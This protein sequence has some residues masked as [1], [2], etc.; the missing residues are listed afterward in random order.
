MDSTFK[1]HGALAF[2]R[3]PNHL[4]NHLCIQPAILIQFILCLRALNQ[5]HF[6]K[7]VAMYIKIF[8]PVILCIAF[9]S[10]SA[11]GQDAKKKNKSPV[12]RIDISKI[13]GNTINGKVASEPTEKSIII[14]IH[15]PKANVN[16]PGNK[17]K[18][19]PPTPDWKE[20]EVPIR[21]NTKFR[22]KEPVE[23][24]DEKGNIKVYTSQDL[25][26]LKGSNPNLPGY[27]AK[28]ENIVP[29]H[30]VTITLAKQDNKP[31]ASMIM[32]NGKDSSD[33]PNN[34]P[35]NPKGKK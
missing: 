14:Q 20:L 25:K 32:V 17:G 1:L 16:P 24:F 28:P 27:E 7:D 13:N 31:F 21:E 33:K 4:E 2:L 15:N 5:G 18:N 11:L 9:L 19:T 29:G 6:Q 22:F 3:V 26:K 10:F 34:K 8:P 12:D 23:A 35:A 30:L